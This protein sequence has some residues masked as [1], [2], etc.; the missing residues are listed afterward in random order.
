MV[1]ETSFI[2]AFFAI[3]I[4]CSAMMLSSPLYGGATPVNIRVMAAAV[5]SLSLTPVLQSQLVFAPNNLIELAMI[6]GREAI[7]GLLI[8]M[9]MQFLVAAI[10]MAGAVSDMQIGIGSAQLFNPALGGQTSP[11][12]QFKFWLGVV[13]LFLLNAH[14]LMFKAF[15]SSFS[16]T[17]AP[18]GSSSDVIAHGANLLAQLL[19]LSVQIAAPIV[20][21]TV[22]I[23]VAS[24]LINRAVPQ[25]QPF[26]ISLPAKLALGLV[27]LS[28][29]LPALT[30][31]V[32]R[33]VEVTF[34]GMGHMMGG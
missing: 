10:Q 27:A 21:V 3:F 12:G 18:I 6:M 31:T 34:A 16:L 23:D 32:Q 7:F 2:L 25:T 26:L 33:G 11:I 9:C 24:G 15:M 22:V 8:G 29:G 30:I 4:R 19:I 5:I 1:L 28:L 14:Q 20:A 13:L 17:G